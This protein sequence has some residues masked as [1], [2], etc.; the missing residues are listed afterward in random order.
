[1]AFSLPALYAVTSCLQYK[2]YDQV[3]GKL[4]NN[5]YDWTDIP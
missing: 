5:K 2:N 4:D 1:M 3:I